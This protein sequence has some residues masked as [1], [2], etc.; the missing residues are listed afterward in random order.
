[1]PVFVDI[2]L[3]D[4]NIDPA[5]IEARITPR[6]R[7]IMPVHLYGQCAAMDQINA[8]ARKHGIAVVEDAAQ[9]VGAE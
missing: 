3:D 2:S 8:I 9:A 7:A 1:M 5:Q 4:Y 6:T